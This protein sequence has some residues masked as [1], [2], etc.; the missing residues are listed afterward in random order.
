MADSGS[1]L[2]LEACKALQRGLAGTIVFPGSDE[3]EQA[4]PPFIAGFEEIA[5]RAV[6]RCASP[7]DATQAIAFAR[8]HGIDVAARSGGHSFAGYSSTRGLVID[9]TPMSSVVVAGDAAKVG[10]GARLGE[11]YERLLEHGLTV[12]AGTCP[13][14]GVGGLTLGGGHGVLGRAYGLTLD[15]LLEAQVVLADGRIVVCD[16]HHHADLFW[17]LRGA[18]AGNFGV[19]TSL[20]F[21][22]SPAPRMTN[23][24]LAWSYRHA[25]AVVAAWQRW[26][27]YGPD[28]LAADL[29][30]TA[31]A[32]PATEPLV[33]VYGAVRRTRSD[34]SRLLDGLVAGVGAEP[35]SRFCRELS[36]RD[37]VRYQA[38]P[39]DGDQ[40]SQPPHTQHTQP[41]R[42]RQRF[43]KSEFFDRPLPHGAI[44]ALVDNLAERRAPGQDRNVTF[45]P[46]GGAYNRLAPDATAFVHRRQRFLLEH[47]VFVEPESSAAA[48]QAAHQWV[49]RSWGSVHPW[50]AGR[51]YPNFPDPDLDDWGRA[52]YGDNYPRLST[53]KAEYDPDNVFRF[54]QSLPIR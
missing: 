48:K 41:S 12:P 23:F 40:A 45:A 36:Y 43:T 16:E 53:I 50:G 20:T 17:A 35:L 34:A 30:L 14:V 52:Y 22:C 31:T 13:S 2:D 8:R 24:H 1:G 47:L 32:D 5:P 39:S 6:V 28:E 10:A 49:T 26:A 44:A 21:R 38:E 51:V 19:V 4:R 46:W 25:A 7:E 9:V 33:A 29:A 42:Q 54:E 18:G 11:L 15:H 27:P 37:T 3:Y